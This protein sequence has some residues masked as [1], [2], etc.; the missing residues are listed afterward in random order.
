MTAKRLAS[1]L[2]ELAAQLCSIG[3]TAPQGLGLH[4]EREGES[5]YVEASDTSVQPARVVR[6]LK[7]LMSPSLAEFD[8]AKASSI[9]QTRPPN[10]RG[11][12]RLRGRTVGRSD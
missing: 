7:P 10:C 8:E 9:A 11:S 4:H 5:R 12:Y 2:H 3:N 6:L 1:Q